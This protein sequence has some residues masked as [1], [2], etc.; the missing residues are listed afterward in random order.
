MFY[1][2]SNYQEQLPKSVRINKR[3]YARFKSEKD[4]FLTTINGIASNNER[5]RYA[6]LLL[7]R[8]MFLYFIQHKGLLDNDPNYLSRHLKITKDSDLNFYRRFL[9]PLFQEGLSKSGRSSQHHM[10]HGNVP[11]LDIDLLKEHSLERDNPNIHIANEAFDRLFSFFDASRWHLDDAQSQNSTVI[12]PD[13]LGYIFEKQDNQKQM[14]AYYTREDI[15]SYIATNAIIPYLFDAVENK[16][17]SSFHPGTTIW[18]QLRMHPQRYIYPYF[19]KGMELALPPE[20]AQGI[21]AIPQRTTWKH[22]AP[23]ICA[24]PGETWRDVVARRRRY[25]EIYTKLAA[26]EIHCINDLI[27]YNLDLR[28]FA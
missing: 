23:A 3:F 6:S 18:Q 13:M 24:L 27:T 19:K 22:P 17:G 1:A 4:Y 11:F 8:L 10:L 26:G 16:C 15:A 5:S 25:E 21:D 12:T 28:Q 14:G 9:L 2:P 7:N 20:I